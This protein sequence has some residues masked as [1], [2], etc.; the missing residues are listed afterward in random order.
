MHRH[1]RPPFA[2]PV[3]AAPEQQLRD[4]KRQSAPPAPPKPADHSEQEAMLQELEREYTAA[5][6]KLQAAHE[7]EMLLSSRVGDL[8]KKLQVGVRVP[9]VHAAL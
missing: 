6:A 2:L 1:A 3:T 5:L 8:Q 9:A 4:A 7:R